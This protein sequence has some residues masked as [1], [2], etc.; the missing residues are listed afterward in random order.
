M[1]EPCKM[2]AKSLPDNIELRAGEGTKGSGI[3]FLIS[4][5]MSRGISAT[6][7]CV[8]VIILFWETSLWLPREQ[9]LQLVI[10]SQKDGTKSKSGSKHPAC[11]FKSVGKTLLGNLPI[12]ARSLSRSCVL[13]QLFKH[14]W[15]TVW[16]A[17]RV[18]HRSSQQLCCRT[19]QSK[20]VQHEQPAET[21]GGCD[22]WQAN[23][24][25]G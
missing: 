20:A 1:W 5:V 10:A 25:P 12:V 13:L 4:V 14:N 19:E 11:F 9:M 6:S 16:T 7:C 24:K 23:G 2:G 3:D 18:E 22:W 17:E 21:T 15:K 8:R